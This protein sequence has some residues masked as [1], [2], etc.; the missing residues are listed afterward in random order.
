MCQGAGRQ[1]LQWSS[2]TSIT[3]HKYQTSPIHTWG[4]SSSAF[5]FLFFLSSAQN[6][7]QNRIFAICITTLLLDYNL[8]VCIVNISLIH[9]ISP[10]RY[11]WLSCKDGGGTETAPE[12]ETTVWKGASS[13]LSYIFLMSDHSISIFVSMTTL[14]I[15]KKRQNN[16]QL[17]SWWQNQVSQSVICPWT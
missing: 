17:F 5:L 9:V 2:T 7:C 8:Y 10:S 15:F 16:F 1:V 6:S 14:N 13:F 3:L 4:A 11:I 12:G